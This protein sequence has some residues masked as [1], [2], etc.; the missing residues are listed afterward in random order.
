MY[1]M[2]DEREYENEIRELSPLLADCTREMPFSM[3]SA[4]FTDVTGEI[5]RKV[6]ESEEAG[7]SENS[8]ETARDEIERLSPILAAAFGSNPFSG[9]P[10]T[11]GLAERIK[12][13]RPKMVEMRKLSMAR[14]AAAKWVAYATAAAVTGILIL[15]MG[16]EEGGKHRPELGT[17][18]SASAAAPDEVQ[19]PGSDDDSLFSASAG[20]VYPILPTSDPSDTLMLVHALDVLQSHDPSDQELFNGIPEDG[21]FAFIDGLPD[22]SMPQGE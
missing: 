7:A 11:E 5:L 6:E 20:E 4:Y 8:E 17:P 16:R 2:S 21:L 12:E 15:L 1:R 22:M 14:V 3:P 13:A 10:D 18:P 9:R 19:G